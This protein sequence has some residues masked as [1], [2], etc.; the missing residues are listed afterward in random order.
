MSTKRTIKIELTEEA[1]MTSTRHFI[2]A[3]VCGAG[4]VSIVIMLASARVDVSSAR[5]WRADRGA[6]AIGS[7]EGRPPRERAAVPRYTMTSA[8]CGLDDAE[9]IVAIGFYDGRTQGFL[10]SPQRPPVPAVYPVAQ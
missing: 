4:V 7:S 6:E 9:Q 3:A 2:P 5:C 1:V 10:L 8:S